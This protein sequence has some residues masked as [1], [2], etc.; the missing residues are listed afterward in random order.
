LP[1]IFCSILLVAS[2]SPRKAQL[3][4]AGGLA[5]INSI[6]GSVVERERKHAGTQDSSI[7]NR[8]KTT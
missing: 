3:Q 4:K 7:P 2:E 5:V 8:V 6:A 1:S